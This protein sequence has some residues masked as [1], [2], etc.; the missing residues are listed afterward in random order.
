D[1]FKG[2]LGYQIVFA[3]MGFFAI[4]G[5]IITTILLRMIAKKKTLQEVA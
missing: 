1:Q 5:V 2:L 3:L 4:C